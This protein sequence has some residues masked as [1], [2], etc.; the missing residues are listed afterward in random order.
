MTLPRI[1]LPIYTT[2][3][4]SQK[5]S[6]R[7]TPFTVKES[8]VLM[9]AKESG[10]VKSMVDALKQVLTNCLVDKLDINKLPM[11]DLEWLFL[12]IY[13][14]S[15]GEKI[16]V[17]FKCTNT[18]QN[19]ACGMI[20]QCDVDLNQIKLEIPEKGFGKIMLN[21]TIGVQLR[22]PT[23]EST[24]KALMVEQSLQDH[25]MAAMCI[26]YIFDEQTVTRSDDATPEEL[27]EFVQQIEISK[28]NEIEKFL[29]SIPNISHKVNTTCV[30]CGYNHEIKLEGLEDF[31]A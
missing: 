26:D 17:H 24:Q 12:Q 14:K 23:F 20:L 11:V 25:M 13:M 1:D 15:S 28:Y 22:L 19:N 9:M 6:V 21:E 30:K 29:D 27:L 7:F 31:F 8:T 4:C 3:I 2:N 18:Y 5:A 10:E 16:P